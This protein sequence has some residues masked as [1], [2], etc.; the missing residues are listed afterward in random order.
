[1]TERPVNHRAR[2][3]ARRDALLRAAVEIVA[4]RGVGG[5]THRAIAQRAGVPAS[6]TTYFFSSIDELVLAALQRF[7][8]ERVAQLEALGDALVEQGADAVTL[9]HTF[10]EAL[11]AAPAQQEVALFEAYLDAQRREEEAQ[12]MIATVLSTFERVAVRAVTPLGVQDPEQV[13]AIYVSLADGYSLRRL[14]L[15]DPIDPA[16]LA[17]ALHRLTLSYLQMP[18]GSALPESVDEA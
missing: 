15:G 7:T 10:A 11:C 18:P 4:E 5:A 14:V 9:A 1:M 8:Q 12:R 13:A 16:P 2:G 6:T 17:D 3:L